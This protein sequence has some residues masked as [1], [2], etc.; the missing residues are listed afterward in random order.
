MNGMRWA[1]CREHMPSTPKVR[2]DRVAATFDGQLDDVLRIEVLGVGRERRR[3]RV[4][5][6]LVDGQ[7]RHVTRVGEAAG[8][9]QALEVAQHLGV[10]S[11]SL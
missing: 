4:L 2:G 10:R 5:D 8:A 7:D 6:A 11:V 3:R 9:E 1:Y